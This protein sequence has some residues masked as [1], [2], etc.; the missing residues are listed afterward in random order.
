MTPFRSMLMSNRAEKALMELE[1]MLTNVWWLRV[2][3]DED[4]DERRRN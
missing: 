2:I 1:G 4:K 3:I